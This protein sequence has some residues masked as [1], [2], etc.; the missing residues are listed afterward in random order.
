[1]MISNQTSRMDVVYSD[2]FSE[3]AADPS[4]PP[5]FVTFHRS[6]FCTYFGLTPDEFRGR[7]VLETGAGP[8]K[9]A[10]VLCLLGAHVTAVDLL[11]SNVRAIERLKTQHAFEHLVVRQ[12]D[13]TQPLPD[14]LGRFDLIS[15][16]NW[17]M[18]SEDPR[19]VLELLADRLNVGGRFYLSLYEAG[20]FRFFIT[21]VARR[22]LA[23][24]DRDVLKALIPFHFPSGFLEFSN[25][26]DI[27]FENI[28]D[29]FFVPYIWT[30][31]YEPLVRFFKGLGF[32]VL[33]PHAEDEALYAIDNEALKVG[34]IKT[35]ERSSGLGSLECGFDE[36]ALTHVRDAQARALMAESAEWAVRAIA[37]LREGSDAS[38]RAAFCLGLYRL[39]GA[40]SRS[41]GVEERHRAL[42]DYLRRVATGDMSSI[43]AQASSRQFFAQRAD[44]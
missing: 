27:Y 29:D 4:L 18:H 37:V 36:F 25:A 14:E 31:R 34:F 22:V 5:G 41:R 1:M 42:Q 43:R 23:W 8:G 38:L 19:R 10:A 26:G 12:A 15:S 11:E 17:L 6:N 39:R 30:F 33:V 40:C 16:H 3:S 44:A 9:H 21:Q 24:E 32:S 28:L 7:S 13:L 35:A 2:Q 20:T